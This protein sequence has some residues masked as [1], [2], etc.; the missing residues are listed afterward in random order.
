MSERSRGD[1][2]CSHDRPL[3][4]RSKRTTLRNLVKST[5]NQFGPMHFQ[6]ELRFSTCRIVILKV[7]IE[8]V[9]V[10]LRDIRFR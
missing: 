8:L 5:C 6:L 1:M 2:W 10:L 9:L 3:S 7:E 4:K